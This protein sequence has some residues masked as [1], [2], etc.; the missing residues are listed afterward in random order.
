MKTFKINKDEFRCYLFYAFFYSWIEDLVTTIIK[1]KGIFWHLSSK[2]SLNNMQGSLRL[3]LAIRIKWKYFSCLIILLVQYFSMKNHL[4]G[5]IVRIFELIIYFLC[6]K[7]QILIIFKS[8]KI[9]LKE[10]LYAESVYT[11]RSVYIQVCKWWQLFF[12]N[13]TGGLCKMSGYF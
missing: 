2:K 8:R 5:S 13:L 9:L 4:C 12:K 11:G 6:Q 10:Q 7:K 3:V 1:T